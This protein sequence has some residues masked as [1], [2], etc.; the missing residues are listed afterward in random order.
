MTIGATNPCLQ[1]FPPAYLYL[2]YNS[3]IYVQ[4]FVTAFNNYA[5]SYLNAMNALNLPIY[6]QQQQLEQI[7]TIVS[8]GTYNSDA[9]DCLPYNSGNTSYF[10]Y[11]EIVGLL[12]WVGNGLYGIERPVI[13]TAT[14]NNDLYCRV[15]TWNLYKGDGYQ[16]TNQWLKRRVARFLTGSYGVDPGIDETYGVS[17]T[18]TSASAIT[19]SC[20]T[21]SYG[22]TLITQF[23]E[24]VA[25]GA[26][27]LPFQYTFTVTSH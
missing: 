4:A 22:G 16:F 18:Y 15:L 8:D 21:A 11:G 26:L 23:S 10:E 13:G 5:Q 12:D 2:E 14:V 17:V 24:L 3:D 25:S 27:S 20:A 6:T 19:I 7:L 9:Y 1:T